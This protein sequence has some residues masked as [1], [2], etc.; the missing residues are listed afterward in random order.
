[1]LIKPNIEKIA[2]I[3]V[4]GVG[5]G[6]G[7]A[8]NTMINKGDIQGV[9]FMAINTDKQALN[10]SKS[11]HVLQIGR[12]ITNGLGSGSLPQIGRKAAEESIEEIREHL[13]GY[14]M[15]FITA[16]MG[17]GTGT[18]AAPVVA[19]VAKELGSLTVSVVT[20]PFQFEGPQRQR[21]A[22][23]GILELKSKVDALIVI[24]NEKLF[25]LESDNLKLSNA[26][27][28]ADNILANGVKGISDLIVKPGLINV[29]FAD[30]QTVMQNAGT[31]LMGIG[32]ASGENRAFTAAEQ[33]ISSPLLDIDVTGA[34]GILLNIASSDSLTLP[35]VRVI[36]KHVTESTGTNPNVILGTS[37]E[38]ELNE[39]TIRVTLI[40]TGFEKP[41][42]VNSF[43]YSI[44]EVKETTIAAPKINKDTSVEKK[45]TKEDVSNLEDFD[46][47][48]RKS[49]ENVTSTKIKSDFN[50]KTFD[51]A[52]KV[53]RKKAPGFTLNRDITN[54]QKAPV[55]EKKEGF[56]GSILKKKK[57]NKI[58]IFLIISAFILLTYRALQFDKR[59]PDP[60]SEGTNKSFTKI[61]Y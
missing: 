47:N 50:Q 24:P 9:E 61:K 57:S 22:E 4:V 43:T 2:N 54:T 58:L 26:F 29:D 5:G 11:E 56:F 44:P 31:A 33:A 30:V 32:E 19:G 37:I 55:Q 34:T 36:T 17:G 40:A 39:D 6:G 1:M 10:L 46:T 45:E 60:L 18:G 3:L 12:E 21:N 13:Q 38:E 59:Y 27:K 41:L 16:G 14:D 28:L 53:Q 42:D 8:I 35:E 48:L 7:N 25:E 51:D 23:E 49:S 20:K 15:I 52:L